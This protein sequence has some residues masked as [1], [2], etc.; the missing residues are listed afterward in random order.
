MATLTLDTAQRSLLDREAEEARRPAP[1]RRAGARAGAERPAVAGRAVAAERPASL[2]AL[3][4]GA[5]STL[6]IAR[7]ASC[8][9]CGDDLVPR[10]GSGA[11][12]VAGA[13]RSCGTEL[14]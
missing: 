12:P 11:H 6:S 9:L 5:W 2:D 14:S 8:P 4:T 7:S 10:Y 3:I 1:A 13:C